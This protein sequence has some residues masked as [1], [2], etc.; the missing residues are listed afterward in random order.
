MKAF[1]LAAL[2]ALAGAM[3]KGQKE[4]VREAIKKAEVPQFSV[5]VDGVTAPGMYAFTDAAREHTYIDF[6]RFANAPN[7]LFNVALHEGHHLRGRDH[8]NVPG[9]PM[10][11]RLT[12]DSNGSV[13]EDNFHLG[14]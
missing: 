12:V 9:D 5:V 13:V 1:F 11:Y 6:A 3:T 10:S 7:S 8:N 14:Q 4:I 2:A